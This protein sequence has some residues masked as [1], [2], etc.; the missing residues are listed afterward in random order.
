MLIVFAARRTPL[1][2][3]LPCS[4]LT[5]FVNG[6]FRS[7]R[8]ANMEEKIEGDMRLLQYSSN[9]PVEV[10]QS[11]TFWRKAQVAL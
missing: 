8:R 7:L 6:L 3:A 4:V 2:R 11:K 9:V 5:L 10:S 1:K